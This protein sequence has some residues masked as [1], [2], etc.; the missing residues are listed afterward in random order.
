MKSKT[1][2]REWA[3]SN[4]N[5]ISGCSNS[6]KYCYARDM[7]I[8]YKRE[9]AETWP[10]EH[11]RTTAKARKHKGRVMFPT[12][13]DLHYEHVSWWGPFLHELLEKGNDVLIVTK[14]E[15]AAIKWICDQFR[16]YRDKIE[17]RFTIGTNDDATAKYWEPGA[18]APSDR[19]TAL[20]RAAIS[21]YK[22]SISMEPL[23]I[24]QPK[25]M[26][27][28]LF[29]GCVNGEIWI[30]CMNH[31]ALNPE[32]PEEARQIKI[33]GRENMQK[34]YESLKDN[35]QIRWKD[36]VQKLLNITS[37]GERL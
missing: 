14:P 9:T 22:T 27:D 32:I 19:L 5:C 33:Q 7:A 28:R 15:Y 29:M 4:E 11:P 34:V 6:C 12:T 2:T 24:E 1:G 25:E 20:V 18:P 16:G 13:H 35:P 37:T 17:F 30:G 26:I 8:L 23:L 21:G 3:E 36:S 10:I 31:Y